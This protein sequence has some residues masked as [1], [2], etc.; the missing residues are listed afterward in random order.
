MMA[1]A[2]AVTTNSHVCEARQRL[3]FYEDT[4]ECT[5]DLKKKKKK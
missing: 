4:H 3:Y 2:L 1:P 5:Q